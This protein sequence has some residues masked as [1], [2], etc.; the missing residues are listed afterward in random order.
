MN[1]RAF[2]STDVGFVLVSCVFVYLHLF[3]YPVVPIIYEGD[4]M[5]FIQDAWRMYRGEAIYRDHHQVMENF[6]GREA[7]VPAAEAFVALGSPQHATML[8]IARRIS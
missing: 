5:Y 3:V 4:H 8:P 7:H 2:S 6:R 1:T